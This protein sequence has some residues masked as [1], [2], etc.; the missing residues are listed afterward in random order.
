[1]KKMPITDEEIRAIRRKH[2]EL[3][4]NLMVALHSTVPEMRRTFRAYFDK[5]RDGVNERYAWP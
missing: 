5:I 2:P 3:L 4:D 1:M